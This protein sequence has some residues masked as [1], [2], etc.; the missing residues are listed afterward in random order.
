MSL[1]DPT[2][3][4][5]L[6]PPFLRPTV[7]VVKN[8]VSTV[9]TSP[10]VLKPLFGM[11]RRKGVLR[12]WAAIAYANPKL[13]TDDLVDIFAVPAQDRGATRTLGAL[14]KAASKIS[15]SPSVKTVLPT[16]TIP[17]LLIWGQKDK[18]VPPAL[19]PQFAKYNNNLELLTLEEV[20]HCP[21][22]ECPEEVN[23][24]ILDWIDKCL[25]MN[26]KCEEVDRCRDGEK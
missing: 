7:A 15:F 3:E 8:I 22:D 18:F 25:E 5:E 26:A 24:A 21:H 20:G 16:L 2:L 23:R 17:I 12:G 6:L 1:P 13:V 4:Q 19:A 9:V 11:L 10:L 14:V